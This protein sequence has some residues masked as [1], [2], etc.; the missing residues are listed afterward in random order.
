MVERGS[1]WC[2]YNMVRKDWTEE[3]T[4]EQKLRQE[5]ELCGNV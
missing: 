4:L 5:S 1:V 2:Y 3:G